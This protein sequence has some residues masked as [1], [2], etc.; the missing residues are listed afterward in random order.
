MSTTPSDDP[1]AVRTRERLREALRQLV[2]DED[3][4]RVGVAELCREAGVHR[5]TFYGHYDGV[6]DVAADLYATTIDERSAV[7]IPASDSVADLALRYREALVGILEAVQA[8]RTAFR[9]LLGSSVSLG[10]RRRMLTGFVE[11]AEL[12]IGVLR[13]HG[14]A[15]DVDVETASAVIGGGMV[16]AIEAYAFSDEAD[17]L[18]YAQRV[19]THLPAWF[20]VP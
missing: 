4:S 19:Q 3:F 16:G 17:A 10:F 15:A 6:G 2:A 9:S 18:G 7:D 8:E 20:P 11:R 1:R 14:L 5:T 12:A 13:E